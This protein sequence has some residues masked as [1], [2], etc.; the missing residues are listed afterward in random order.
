[1]ILME[2]NILKLGNRIDVK[3]EIKV[4]AYITCSF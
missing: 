4:K 3:L 1:M 2:I